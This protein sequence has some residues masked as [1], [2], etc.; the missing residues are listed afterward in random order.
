[1]LIFNI[2]YLW[3]QKYIIIAESRAKK[4]VWQFLSDMPVAGIDSC[5]GF[6]YYQNKYATINL[7]STYSLK[8]SKIA[9]PSIPP[10]FSM[11]Y[12]TAV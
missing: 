7:V 12:S 10:P 8:K 1:M 3:L 5:A 4:D 6:E 9:C 2:V 11:N